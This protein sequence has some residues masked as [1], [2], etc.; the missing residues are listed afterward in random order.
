M[1]LVIKRWFG[2]HGIS[3]AGFSLQRPLV[4]GYALAEARRLLSQRNF[5]ARLQRAMVEML[6]TVQGRRA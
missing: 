4:F 2:N 5:H 6:A 3:Y 1:V